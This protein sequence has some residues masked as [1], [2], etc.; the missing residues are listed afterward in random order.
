MLKEIKFTIDLKVYPLEAVYGAS[1]VFIDRAYIF[2]ESLKNS[3]VEVRFKAKEENQEIEKIKN[4]FFNE[5]LNYAL[6]LKISKHNHKLREFVVSQAL[7][8]SLGKEKGILEDKKEKF[9]FEDDPLGIAVPWEEKY[10]KN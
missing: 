8:A 10:G 1:Y 4:E 2:L 9:E 7:F 3:K 5:L 6:R